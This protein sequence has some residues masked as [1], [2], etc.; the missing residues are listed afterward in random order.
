M[1]AF[2]EE[3]KLRIDSGLQQACIEVGTLTNRRQLIIRSVHNENRTDA[4]R[5]QF[6]CR[7]AL[8][9]LAVVISKPWIKQTGEVWHSA[10][11]RCRL[12]WFGVECA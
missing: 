10:D 3:M 11:F 7:A 2:A 4:A 5:G 1:G 12:L 6:G 9:D 8:D